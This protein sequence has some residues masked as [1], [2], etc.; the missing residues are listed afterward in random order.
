MTN[1]RAREIAMVPPLLKVMVKMRD[2]FKGPLTGSIFKIKH[3]PG[4]EYSWGATIRDEYKKVV[5]PVERYSP[6]CCRDWGNTVLQSVHGDSRIVE[7]INGHLSNKGTST[8]KYGN[9][10]LEAKRDA[11]MLLVKD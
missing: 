6:K 8:A 10:T 1:Q 9:I 4:D 7:S 11:L 3:P 5:S 2:G